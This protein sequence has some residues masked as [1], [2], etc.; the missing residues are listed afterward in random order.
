[1]VAE[2]AGEYSVRVL[3]YYPGR[4][5]RK[6]SA[7]ETAAVECSANALA[8]PTGVSAVCGSDGVLAV[9]WGHRGPLVPLGLQFDV[10]VDGTT[11]GAVA[12]RSTPG[13]VESYAY[14]WDGAHSNRA[15]RVRVRVAPS[16]AGAAAGEGRESPWSAVV[17]AGKCAVFRP[18]GFTTATCNSHGVVRLEWDPVGGADRY[19]LKNT[20]AGEESVSYEGP[21]TEVYAQRWE[22]ET[23]KIRIRAR[24]RT[25]QQWSGWTEPETVTCADFSSADPDDQWDSPNGQRITS[26]RGGIGSSHWIDPPLYRYMPGPT[27]SE[28]L[29]R[30]NCGPTEPAT[31]GGW[32]RTCRVYWTEPL[33]IQLSQENFNEIYGHSQ[34]ITHEATQEAAHIHITG[35]I[36]SI[37]PHRHC[38]TTDGACPGPANPKAPDLAWHP[39]LPGPG[40]PW[41]QTAL[42]GIGGTAAAGGTTYG[43]TKLIPQLSQRTGATGFLL[44][45]AASVGIA[46]WQRDGDH[47]NLT[48]T[49]ALDCLNHPDISGWNKMI[50]SFTKTSTL[51][52][53]TTKT[54]TE[55]AY[56]QK[57]VK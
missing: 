49:G 46:F 20:A 38:A 26:Y 32:T 30:D 56:C 7:W 17:D 44:G 55:I 39:P 54:I 47:Y 14:R 13:S 34:G 21:A 51:G 41:W 19:D 29:G 6:Y 12:Y 36:A 28:T 10:E 9:S 45:S 53:Y 37:K 23:Y 25:G 16:L 18:S 42:I 24:A 2:E 4:K 57:Q 8:A 48:I 40:D 52:T 31:D 43:A 15:H 11:V 22:G 35:G 1:L 27:K 33:A 50:M 3:A 5:G